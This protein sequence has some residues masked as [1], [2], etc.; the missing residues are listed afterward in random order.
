M[1]ERLKKL[2][3][4]R[5]CVASVVLSSSAEISQNFGGYSRVEKC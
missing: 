3:P 5:F 4:E 2:D 1:E